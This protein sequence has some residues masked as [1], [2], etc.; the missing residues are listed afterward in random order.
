[1]F[2]DMTSKTE[3]FTDCVEGVENVSG[4]ANNWL[5][6][7]KT[8]CK[9]AFKKIRIRQRTIKPSKA[10]RLIGQRNK[11]LK[12][13]EIQ[14]AHS[15]D[16]TIASII[17]E[18]NIKKALMF[19]KYM[20]KGETQPVSD[21]WKLKQS[22][23]PKKAPSLPSSK[24]NHR[25]KLVTEPAE[26][27]KLLG[28]KYG[29]I[30]LRKRPTHPM[31]RQMNIIRKQLLIMKL[32]SASKKKTPQF[33]MKDLDMVLRGLKSNKARDPEGIARTIFKTSIV[34]S[35]LKLSM[36]KLFNNIK[37]RKEIPAFMRKATVTTIPKKGSKLVLKNERGIFLCKFCEKHIHET[38]I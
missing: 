14:K 29:K 8:H 3:A 10:E 22:L 15:L 17:S 30:R 35:N 34:G 38:I 20:N 19:K 13:G 5:R 36:L 6:L 33:E 25:G 27:V 2:C 31:H 24:F 32:S 26:L 12:Q 23:F 11:L 18:E 16:V 37:T 9:K 1:M 4:Q 28:T 21:M 7:L